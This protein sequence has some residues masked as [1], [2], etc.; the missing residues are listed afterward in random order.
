MNND[1]VDRNQTSLSS[2]TV[3]KGNIESGNDYESST[4]FQ[5]TESSDAQGFPIHSMQ[6]AIAESTA[7]N[8]KNKAVALTILETKKRRKS[9][10][11]VESSSD[12]A[13]QLA[14]VMIGGTPRRSLQ[15]YTSDSTHV[16]ATP[17]RDE[18]NE[19]YGSEDDGSDEIEK[20]LEVGKEKISKGKR[21]RNEDKRK[22]K[23]DG[24]K[25]KQLIP[26]SPSYSYQQQ[27]SS[28]SKDMYIYPKQQHGSSSSKVADLRNIDEVMFENDTLLAIKNSKEEVWKDY[29]KSKF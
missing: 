27:Q 28:S 23:R 1:S 26:N 29:P 12:E 14:V 15:G 10:K 13:E 4:L 24:D 21:K 2:D 22:K 19:S 25:K 6:I 7:E 3:V 9:T 5:H 16:S 8:S 20:V 11:I 18:T 17:P